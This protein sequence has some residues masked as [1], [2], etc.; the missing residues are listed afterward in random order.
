MPIELQKLAW[1]SLLGGGASADPAA[2]HRC[3][4]LSAPALQRLLHSL[5]CSTEL[6]AG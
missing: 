6:I 3:Q 1:G 5:G 4:Q 2:P